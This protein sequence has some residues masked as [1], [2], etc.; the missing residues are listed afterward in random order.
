MCA[1]IT[2]PSSLANNFHVV[3]YNKIEN[4]QTS[5]IKVL[6]LPLGNALRAL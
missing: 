5:N 4:H 6:F 2:I 1:T 3:L